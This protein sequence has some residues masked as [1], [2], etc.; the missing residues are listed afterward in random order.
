MLGHWWHLHPAVRPGGPA[1]RRA[2]PR[3]DWR[4]PA[5]HL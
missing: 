5:P 4:P 2:H 1:A 3:R